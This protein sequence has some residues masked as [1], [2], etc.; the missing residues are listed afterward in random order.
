MQD[1]GIKN[2]V[3]GPFTFTPDGNPLL[4]PVRGVPNYWLACGV[5]AG[6][7]QSGGVALALAQ[8]MIDGEPAE[9]TFAMDP[10]RFGSF[11]NQTY[12]LEMS[13]QFYEW[14]F[15]VAFP[16]EAWPA[17]RPARTTP[18][19]EIQRQAGAVF[20]PSASIELPMW[21]AREGE[22][23][24]D[25]PT[26]RRPNSFDAVGEEVQ[27]ATDGVGVIDISSYSKFEV[28]GSGAR[29]WLD[30]VLASRIPTTG[31][32]R[33]AALLSDKA[34]IVGD[35]MIFCLEPSF[36]GDERF[37]LTGSGPVQEWHMRWFDRYLPADAVE[38]RNVSDDW[39]GLSLVGPKSRE[40]LQ[41]LTRADLS[42]DVFPFLGMRE[43][44]VGLSP[45][46]V[47][48]VSLS[49]ELGFE[50]WMPPMYMHGLY[51]RLMEAGAHVGIRNVG[52][53]AMLSMRLEKDFGIW[54]RELS[55]DY[56]PSQNH[57]ADIVAFQKQDFVGR[58]AALADSHAG[59][60][61][62]LVTLSIDATDA[63][64]TWAERVPV[65]ASRATKIH[66]HRMV[67]FIVLASS[68]FRCRQSLTLAQRQGVSSL[69]LGRTGRHSGGMETLH[70][71]MART[72]PGRVL[73]CRPSR[74][75]RWIRTKSEL[76]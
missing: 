72:P 25:I 51:N 10:T 63:G 12:T 75:A 20:A 4:G 21:F 40:V 46:R 48:R 37:M 74:Q 38:V 13:K 6:F 35:F 49:G 61:M 45:A 28:T 41:Q 52:I 60:T 50:V 24:E 56:L 68:L 67:R 70:S 47:G 11:A 66:K 5:M 8:W 54:G 15:Q 36:D 58:G 29:S 18:I 57:M 17:A 64:A 59:P 42:S 27:A 23:A 62:R 31:R 76:G 30:Y 34:A 26:F 69:G 43:I 9:D 2:V 65:M 22:P 7:S 3:N 16:N 39:M 19:Y 73:A 33:L 53:L 32:G 71:T 14:R 44:E 1:A 55:P